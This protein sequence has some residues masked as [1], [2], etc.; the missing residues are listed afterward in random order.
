MKNSIRSVALA[1]LG[2]VA[3]VAAADA[4]ERI[5]VGYSMVDDGGCP[6]VGH[7][8][9][10]EY[11]L[12]KQGVLDARGRV[13]TAPSG[14]DCRQD[15]LTY[16]ISVARY[17][18]AGAVDILVE[19]GANEQAAS[20]PYALT[21]NGM[22]IPR[23]GDGKPLNVQTLPAGAAT[24]V[25]GVI[26]L[27]RDVGALRISGGYNF[28]PVDWA[29]AGT[30]QHGR[31]LQLGAGWDRG[32]GFSADMAVNIGRSHFGGAS[33]SYRFALSSRLDLGL[34]VLHRWGINAVDNGAPDEQVIEQAVFRRIGAPRNHA[35]FAS[36]TFGWVS[37]R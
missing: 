25:V 3:L 9:V 32:G 20:A 34:G 12:R 4:Q 26:G 2:V 36:A 37:R 10:A 17:F 35:T 33:A 30:V 18:S 19:F 6:E 16:D 7:I 11:D 5:G 27:S 8:L 21:L 24:T 23:P 15:A 14:G 13:R 1:A 28:V 31:S 22:V 29:V